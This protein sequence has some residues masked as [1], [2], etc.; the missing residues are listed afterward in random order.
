MLEH[1]PSSR[2]G[3]GAL[4]AVAAAAV[5]LGAA[6]TALAGAVD[7]NLAADGL[8]L[9]GY[10]PVAYFT[11]GEPTKGSTAYTTTYEGATYRFADAEHLA[12]FEADPAR[13]LPAYGGYCAFGTAMGRKFD[14][15][16]EVWAIVD[17]QLYLN[18][19]ETVQERWEGDIRGLVGTA[20][21]NW[22][23]I[24]DVPDA[25]LE[26]E[27]PAGIRLGAAE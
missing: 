3:R 16:P 18:I 1:A 11:A 6:G 21:H 4:V 22:T 24:E 12:A 10:D 17:G 15:D 13:Y 19:N 23:I 14:G 27:P 20:D 7:K 2:R 8:A 9:E 5:A 26:N 25:Q